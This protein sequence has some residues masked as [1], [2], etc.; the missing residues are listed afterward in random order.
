MNHIIQNIFFSLHSLQ[1]LS[2]GGNLITEIPETVGLLNHLHAL[3]LCDNLLEA[4]PASIARLVNLK[5][6]LLHKNRLRHLPR[7]IITLRNLTEVRYCS[8]MLSVT[9]VVP[10]GEPVAL[11][12]S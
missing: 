5:S 11:M 10:G 12:A 8:M 9:V 6:L 4:L 2:L 3:V 1:L 7:E